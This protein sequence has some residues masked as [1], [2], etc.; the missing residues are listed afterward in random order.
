MSFAQTVFSH[1]WRG[2][3]GRVDYIL[4]ELKER[5]FKEAYG[6]VVEI[7][8]GTGVNF[9]YFSGAV[10]S[11]IG[12]EPNEGLRG[13]L[14]RSPNLPPRAVICSDVSDVGD[15]TADTVV[16]SIVLC[17]VPDLPLFLGEIRRILKPGGIFLSLEHV[18]APHKTFHRRIQRLVKP[19]V[20]WV[21][22]GC[23]PDRDI[24]DAVR[25]AGFANVTLVWQGSFQL[26]RVPFK[27]PFV[28]LRAIA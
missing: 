8:P 4:G 18:G 7:G 27:V 6:T 15:R 19:V 10:L 22:G 14:R 9:K 2:T 5:L 17:S 28:A 24:E 1:I 21:G 12:V 26:S 20:R 3:A 11:W 13:V 25:A 16:S 23:E